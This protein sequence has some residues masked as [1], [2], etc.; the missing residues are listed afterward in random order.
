MNFAMPVRPDSRIALAALGWHDVI[1]RFEETI[2]DLLG[3]DEVD[4][5]DRPRLLDRRG[6]EV[7][8]R[9]NDE[10]PFLIFVAFDE[11]VPRH[12]LPV[13]DTHPLE[14]HRRLVLRVQHPE[15]R[16]RIAHRGM[17]LDRDVDEAERKRSLPER[18]CHEFRSQPEYTSRQRTR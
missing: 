18:A 12:R 1:R 17:Q 15:V 6:L 9:Q 5:V 10:M 2:V 4:D 11:I 3:L 13:P 16:P 7:L 8:L 14:L